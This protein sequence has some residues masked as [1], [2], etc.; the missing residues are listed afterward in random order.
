MTPE[1][2]IAKWKLSTLGE[3][4]AA[5][6]HFLDLCELLGEP[7][8]EDPDRYC[9]ERGALK[10]SGRRG[11]ADVWKRG[12]FAWECKGKGANLEAALAQLQQY[13]LALENPPL[14]VV[15]DL[16]RFLIVTNWTNTVSRRISLRIEELADAKKREILKQV[17]SD[18][19][20]LKPGLMREQITAKRAR[21]LAWSARR[22]EG[23][24]PS[25]RSGRCASHATV[26]SLSLRSAAYRYPPASPIRLPRTN[27]HSVDTTALRG[28][29]HSRLASRRL[30]G[31]SSISITNVR[32]ARVPHI[33]RAGMRRSGSL[34]TRSSRCGSR[35]ART[36]NHIPPSMAK[37]PRTAWATSTT[38]LAQPIVRTVC[39]LVLPE[40]KDQIEQ[41]DHGDES[42]NPA[43]HGVQPE[44]AQAGD[45]IDRCQAH[46]DQQRD[47][48]TYG[49][50]PQQN[51]L[52]VPEGI[53]DPESNQGHERVQ[54]GPYGGSGN[55]GHEMVVQSPGNCK[56]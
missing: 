42:H 10:A 5:Q 36:S 19:E 48:Q 1:Q 31:N 9:F 40:L 53:G 7:K 28:T 12:C 49:D 45:G 15:C 2:F 38:F 21:S 4:Q 3:R 55:P 11:W 41:A 34:P 52:A 37:V 56:Q 18:P 25:A 50:G 51:Q 32:I 20:R 54:N 30:R 47:R 14:L 23:Q 27:G 22:E 17:L 43:H 16:E 24:D 33:H 39:R 13:A 8:P 26:M 46:L 29:I 35:K 44:T 6:P